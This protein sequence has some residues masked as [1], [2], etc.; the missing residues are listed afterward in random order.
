MLLGPLECYES[1][2]WT[3]HVL[4]RPRYICIHTDI[5][6]RLCLNI[7]TLLWLI[8]DTHSAVMLHDCV[9]SVRKSTKKKENETAWNQSIKRCCYDVANILD[10]HLYAGKQIDPF[11]RSNPYYENVAIRI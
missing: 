1:M 6:K 2:W 11:P 10:N 7:Y 9:Q 3:M 8:I 5:I 4:Y